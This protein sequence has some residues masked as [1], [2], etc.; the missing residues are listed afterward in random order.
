MSKLSGEIEDADIR[1]ASPAEQL[2]DSEG[3]PLRTLSQDASDEVVEDFAASS[4]LTN[5]LNVLQKAAALLQGG[6]ELEHTP[7]I[8]PSELRA[9]RRE[10]THKWQQPSLL[11][12]TIFVCSLGAI[13][14]GWAQTGMN[15]ANL[16]LPAA[17]G[18]GSDST[19]DSFV[20]GLINSGI[21]LANALLGSWLAEPVN[22]R[23]GRKGA[24]FSATAL[25]LVGNLGSALS[26]S[27]PVLLIFRLILGT[28]LGLNASTVSVFAAESAPAY[29]RG[30]LAVSWQMFTAFGI[31]LGFLANVAFYDYGP[32]VIWR[33]QLA[34]PL[35]PTIP[36]L[37]VVWLCPESPAWHIKR[38]RYDLAFASLSHLRNTKLQAT[39]ELYANFLSQRRHSKTLGTSPQSYFRKL[40]SLFTVA[41]VRHA[42]LASYVVMLSQ[43]LCGINIIAFYSSSIFESSGFSALAALWAS[44]LFGLVN[45]LGAFPAI[46]TMDKFGRRRLMLWTLPFMAVVMAFASLTFS[47]PKGTTQLIILAGLIY[48]FCALYS[49]G[50]GPVPVPYS[51][52][53]YPSAVR[54]VGMALAISTASTWATILSV[55][56]PSLLAGLGEQRSFGLYAA[57]NVLA[58]LL[59]WTFVRETKG[60][61]LERMDMVFTSSPSSFVA[62][63]WSEGPKTW[64]SR[65]RRGEGWQVVRQEDAPG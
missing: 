62:E 34:A 58:W 48:L 28:G 9:L 12:F 31:F 46:F 59:C 1:M 20:L 8:S 26:W 49:P 41:R 24:I 25:C 36:L 15:G 18:I 6:V 53:I 22:N 43:Q 32:D 50:V 13:E 10:T 57:L 44:V 37:M 52:E 60:V 16:Y 5:E 23:I 38:G 42:V 7:G 4:G 33:L 47:L 65:R 30:G 55:T 63:Q 29:I 61:E 56:F 19:H 27:W 17:I 21:Y 45:F 51:A 39:C 11:Y 54:E 2:E 64:I 40:T 14:Q 3:Q 35:I